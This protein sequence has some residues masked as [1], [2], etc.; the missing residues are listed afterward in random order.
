M[1]R[2]LRSFLN[3]PA[4]QGLVRMVASQQALDTQWRGVVP[5][6]LHKAS[7]AIR[8][9]QGC[10][11]VGVRSHAVLAKLRQ[12]EPSLLANLRRN[13]LQ[14]NALRLQLQVNPPGQTTAK[15]RTNH[16]LSEVALAALEESAARLQDGPLR[17]SML[18]I[19]RRHRGI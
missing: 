9:E 11:W 16:A 10:L 15:P 19:V 1:T 13:G 6:T 7:H 17:E 8:L 5:E 2:D 12:L 4:L 18:R 3:N 14:I